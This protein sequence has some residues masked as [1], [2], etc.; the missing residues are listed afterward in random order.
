MDAH[1]TYTDKKSVLEEKER[2]NEKLREEKTDGVKN[3]KKGNHI[4]KDRT[5]RI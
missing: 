2:R 5:F 3:Q 1:E 4:I